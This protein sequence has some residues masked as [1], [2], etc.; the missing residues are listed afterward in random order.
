MGELKTRPTDRDVTEFLN[1][2]EDEEKRRDCFALADLMQR[3]TGDKPE[4]WGEGMIGFGRYTYRYASGQTGEWSKTGFAPRKQNITI[5]IMAYLE[6]FPEIMQ[7]LG[8][9]KT[10]KSC[11][12]IK[13]LVDIDTSVLEEL[14]RQSLKNLMSAVE[15]QE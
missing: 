9:Y 7:R 4:M 10:G 15:N 1:G 11:I 13:H 8:K 5:Y 12:Y 6:N 2:I 3:I 14:V